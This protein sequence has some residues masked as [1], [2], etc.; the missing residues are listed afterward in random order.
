MNVIHR[1]PAYQKYR[2]C[3]L[4]VNHKQSYDFRNSCQYF[5]KS[6]ELN[7]TDVKESDQEYQD[8]SKQEVKDT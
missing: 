8:V 3:L 5:L 7:S 6:F 4:R 2:A 1:A